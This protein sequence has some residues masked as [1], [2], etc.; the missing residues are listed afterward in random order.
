[1]SKL[2]LLLFVNLLSLSNMSGAQ[3]YYETMTL[4]DGTTLSYAL[5]LPADFD[6]TKAYPTLLALP[7]GPQT[8]E[9]VEAGLGY[10]RSGPERG[11]VIIS[12]VAPGK[13]FFQGAESAIPKLLDEVAKKLN[14]EGGKVHISGISNG[15][16]SSFRIA[17]DYPERIH[18]ILALPGFPPSEADYERL[19]RIAQLPVVMYAGEHD[20]SWVEQMLRTKGVLL[21]LG[22]NVSATVVPN[23]D[24]VIQSLNGELLFGL[25]ET[26]R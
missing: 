16:R 26:F 4:K 23:E 10:W 13:L 7:P 12:P 15:G 21:D 18:S 5:L 6:E 2:S 22:A 24:H 3:N 20:T 19:E 1:M 11:W 14:F 17:L 9:M 25:L 8:K